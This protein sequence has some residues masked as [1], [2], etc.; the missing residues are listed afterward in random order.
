M[1]SIYIQSIFQCLHVTLP[2]TQL[3]V[4]KM[5]MGKQAKLLFFADG[6]NVFA[7]TAVFQIALFSN[8]GLFFD[9]SSTSNLGFY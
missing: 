2:S 7:M 5:E 3:F 8:K 1:N 9:D 4:Y 6:N